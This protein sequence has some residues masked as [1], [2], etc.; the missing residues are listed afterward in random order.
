MFSKSYLQFGFSLAHHNL[1]TFA[2]VE[3]D[4]LDSGIEN[5][6]ELNRMFDEYYFF[7][8]SNTYILTSGYSVNIAIFEL[9]AS[10]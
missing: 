10:F 3:A 2:L 6:V 7:S 8:T 9:I 5:H 4:K 1:C